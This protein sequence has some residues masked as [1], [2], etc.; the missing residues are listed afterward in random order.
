MHI[1]IA[2]YTLASLAHFGHNAE[3]V[4]FY[5]GLPA[6]MTRE[7]VYLVWLAVASVG[8][9]SVFASWRG[10]GHVGA[11][12]LIVYGLLGVDG[13]LHYTLALCSQHTL[14]TNVTIFA[15][16]LLGIALACAAA[17]RLSRLGR[18]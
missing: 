4:A 16:V 1:L 9:A 11:A 10:W 17:V 7:S 15:E 8:A 13:L 14:A 6:W 3:Y 2:A 12:L 18:L 5:P